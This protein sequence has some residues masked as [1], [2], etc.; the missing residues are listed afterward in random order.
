MAFF[1][2]LV[3]FAQVEAPASEMKVSSRL[4]IGQLQAASSSLGQEASN[5]SYPGGRWVNFAPKATLGGI[6][7]EAEGF[8]SYSQSWTGQEDIGVTGEFSNPTFRV[9]HNWITPFSGFIDGLSMSL[10]GTMPVNKTSE[11]M[12]FNGSLSIALEASKEIGRLSLTQGFNLARGFFGSDDYGSALD[13]PVDY[14]FRS[15]TSVSMQVLKSLKVGGT[16]LAYL[17]NGNET[18]NESISRRLQWLAI[19]AF[20]LNKIST[21]N[22]GFGSG[23][24]A[25]NPDAYSDQLG[26]SDAQA[27]QV[28]VELE[29][30][31]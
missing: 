11:D 23:V 14:V 26:L 16:I 9:G 10:I 24:G 18:N 13:V 7:W 5:S 8:F 3:G 27:K 30:S 22:W 4:S 20:S 12:K 15:A 31:I 19:G 1:Y 25:N 6:N 21:L 17:T 28:F 2:S 29:I